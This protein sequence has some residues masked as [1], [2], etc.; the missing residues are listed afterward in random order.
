M[1]LRSWASNLIVICAGLVAVGIATGVHVSTQ[2]PFLTYGSS[3][4]TAQA[5]SSTSNAL[6]VSI[7]ANSAASIPF[8]L[9][10]SGLGTT[11]T[12]GINLVNTTAATGG[13]TVQISPRIRLRGN[14]WDTSASETSDAIIE[15]LPTSAATP[16]G[17]LKFGFSLNGGALSYPLTLKDNGVMTLAGAFSQT[18]SGQIIT[19][20]ADGG[21]GHNGRARTA[22]TADK[23]LQINDSANSTGMELN[24]G[25]PTLGT[26]TGGSLTSG[27]HNFAGQ[28]TGNTSGSCAINFGTPNFTQTPFCFAMSTASTT[29]PR[30]SASSTSSITV[31]GGVSGETIQYFCIGRIGT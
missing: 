27:S 9:N 5:I 31:T 26:C 22:S 12:D 7:Q 17:L 16:S 14:A 11:S 1:R 18:G 24:V 4:G 3:S 28:Y 21:F 29:H 30:I 15:N 19:V 8:T 23:L 10:G 20:A 13:A 25:T 6:W 2:Q